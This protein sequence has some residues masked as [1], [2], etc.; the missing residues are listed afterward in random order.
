MANLNLSKYENLGLLILRLS[1]GIIFLVHGIQK[2]YMWNS[3]AN[4]GLPASSVLIFKI[5]AIAEPLGGLALILGILTRYAALGFTIIM[6]GA[7]IFKMFIFNVGFT[8]NQGP[9]W[10][11]DLTLLAA[12]IYLIIKGAGKYALKREETNI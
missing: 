9:G 3:F 8:T 12:S 7:I 5:L 4:M 11:F 10:E 1:T 6:V 2:L